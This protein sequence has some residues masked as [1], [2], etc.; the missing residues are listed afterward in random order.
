MPPYQDY[1]S[2]FNEVVIQLLTLTPTVQSVSELPH[3]E[4]ELKFVKIFRE[5]A[6]LKNILESFSEFQEDDLAL[7]N[8]K[9][10]DYR[11]AYLDLYDKV[12]TA[13]QKET[14]SIL[15]DVDFELELIHRD[16]INVQYILT[17]AQLYESEVL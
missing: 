4:A 13:T 1:V 7:S 16:V 8:Q 11:S 12:K 17:L 10:A 9:F 14:A 15:D 6:R 3:E 5:P 2:K